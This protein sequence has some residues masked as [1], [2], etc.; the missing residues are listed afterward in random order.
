LPS[1]KPMLADRLVLDSLRD[2]QFPPFALLGAVRDA[3]ATMVA[4]EQ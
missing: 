4:P 2:G 1:E 3:D